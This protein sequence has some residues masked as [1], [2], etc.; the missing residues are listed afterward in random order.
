[1]DDKEAGRLFQG[2]EE[3]LNLGDASADYENF[4]R[5][6]PS[7]FPVRLVDARDTAK[8]LAW[9]PKCCRL[10]LVF[11]DALHQLW[12]T[13]SKHTL[14]LLLGIDRE[15][16]DLVNKRAEPRI[17]ARILGG[18]EIHLWEA[19]KEIPPEYCADLPSLYPDWR[20]GD[21][22]YEPKN[23]FQLAVYRLWRQS[24]RAKECRQCVKCF[25]ADKPAQLYCSHKCFNSAKQK[26]GLEWWRAHG[27]E[28]RSTA[29]TSKRTGRAGRS[30]RKRARR[31]EQ[32]EK[33]Q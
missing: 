27:R 9:D 20:T 32:K 6:W 13:R 21:F 26:R 1:M 11:R 29:E 2:L 4:S 22:Q 31:Q 8:V 16:W 5:A 15:L 7:F 14:A 12:R 17:L 28:W 23:D 3:F 30:R 18:I 24:W 33:R 25:V 19:I 10:V